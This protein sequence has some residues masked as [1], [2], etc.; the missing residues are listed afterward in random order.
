MN[1]DLDAL[2]RDD[3]LRPPTDFTQRVMQR[4]EQQTQGS[5]MP[6][7]MQLVVPLVVPLAASSTLPRVTR[8]TRLRW[9]LTATGLAASGLLGISQLASFVF[10]WW[11][12]SAAV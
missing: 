2:L 3:L 7:V 9:L 1:N 5:L 11:L 4:I 10:G 6:P 8:W 12:V